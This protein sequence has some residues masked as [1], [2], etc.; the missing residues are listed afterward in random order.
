MSNVP[1][2]TNRPANLTAE[3]QA[4]L[5]ASP[6]VRAMASH[7]ASPPRLREWAQSLLDDDQAATTT[8]ATP[9]TRP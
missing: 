2:P 9:A 6:L 7:T 5:A 8:P 3:Q 1:C 4:R